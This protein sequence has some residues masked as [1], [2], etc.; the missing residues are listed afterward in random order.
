MKNLS[1]ICAI[2][3]SFLL[4]ACGGNSGSTGGNEVDFSSS[5][6]DDF[7]VDDYLD[8][9]AIGSGF[10]SGMGASTIVRGVL[11]D[12]RSG[13]DYKTIQFGPYVWMAENVND[14]IHSSYGK[15]YNNDSLLCEL[16]GKLY[17]EEDAAY[18][19]PQ[20][21]GLPSEDDYKY[22]IR[23]AG[24]LTDPEFGF[25]PQMGGSCVEEKGTVVCSNAGLSSDLV[26]GD[27]SYVRIKNKAGALF[28]KV[29]PK[30]YYSV[31]CMKFT[32]FVE[33]KKLLP[34]CDS[35]AYRF[36]DI[37]VAS[38]GSNFRCKDGKWVDAVDSYCP[39]SERGQRYYYNDVLYVCDGSWKE[40]TMN[41]LDEKCNSANEW[42]VKKLN[43]KSYICENKEW[44][45]PTEIE[46]S[47][48]LCTPERLGKIDSLVEPDTTL[49]YCGANGWR[50]AQLSDF[51]G[52]CDSTRYYKVDSYRGRHY[53]CR[54]TDKWDLLDRIEDS[55]GVCSP[56]I[57]GKMDTLKM[58][59][60]T[61][62]YYCD[63]TSW[64]EATLTDAYGECDSTKSYKVVDFMGYTYT[65][66]KNGRWESLTS[67]E[68]DIGVCTPSRL[69]KIDT[70]TSK[71]DY[72]CDST[73]WRSTVVEDYFGECDEKQK[74]TTLYFKGSDYGC[75]KGPKWTLLDFPESDLGYCIP[76]IKGTIRIDHTAK[77]YICDSVWRAA[78]KEEVLGTCSDA[79]EGERKTYGTTRY[80]CSFEAWR[81]S[82]KQDDSLG[83][84][85]KKTLKKVG[86]VGSTEYICKQ[87]GWVTYTI[88][89]AHDSCTEARA[90]TVVEFQ[91]KKYVC[92]NKAWVALTGV[93]SKYGLCTSAESGNL[94]VYG[95]KVFKCV[96]PNWTEGTVSDLLG[97]CTKAR[98]GVIDTVGTQPYFCSESEGWLPYTTLDQE[99]GF[100]E[101]SKRGTIKKRNGVEY[102][103]TYNRRKSTPRWRQVDGLDSTFGFCDGYMYEWHEAGGNDYLCGDEEDA[104]VRV[105]PGFFW[106]YY[107]YCD[108]RATW[109]YGTIVGMQGEHFYCD[110]ALEDSSRSLVGWHRITEI[111]SAAGLRKGDLIAGI[112]KKGIAGDTITVKDERYFCGLNKSSK[113][114]WIKATKV[115]DFYGKCGTS[116][117]GVRITFDGLN[118][119]CIDGVWS[120]DAADYGSFKDSRDGR[121]YKT[122]QIGDQVWMA[123]NLRYKA[124]GN[125][126][127]PDNNFSAAAC[128]T[129]GVLYD[130][131]TAL[132]L[133]SEANSIIYDLADTANH[134]GICPDGWRVPTETDWEELAEG[135]ALE[136]LRLPTNYLDTVSTN[137]YGFSAKNVG[138]VYV[139]YRNG[140]DRV[141]EFTT[142]TRYWTTSQDTYEI[143]NTGN[144]IYVIDVYNGK[145]S[146]IWKEN[147]NAL[148]CIKK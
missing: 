66:R 97:S 88:I 56:K 1:L 61:T 101:K 122:I 15:C 32:Y 130:W 48:G 74:Y 16:Y 110:G 123:E 119:Q 13:K 45:L 132:A 7:N 37:F 38:E 102:G 117:A 72:Y 41:D 50:K 71:A 62:L 55:L 139:W 75:E 83:V 144:A 63:T 142:P 104:W 64:R 22:M 85:S 49:Y 84:C 76:A 4:F 131:A 73:G 60:D 116:N 137:K 42:T 5:S 21:F 54:T 40:A 96:P 80:V 99:L 93:E 36:G 14:G 86:E 111:D 3:F 11:N 20:G 19:C 136:D 77:D 25:N 125:T 30:G 57:A 98:L 121:V 91:S 108:D 12:S 118:L 59:F 35:S 141:E 114:E 39:S 112:C 90:E 51:M 17:L 145:R 43:G 127:C 82:T 33:N 138:Y 106:G 135:R 134:Q 79:R 107:T 26:T 105:T 52:K 113:Y 81:T 28:G 53:T 103:C 23:F 94:V 58:K 6:V 146:Y 34:D 68:K 10:N 65:C 129:D 69:G 95:N 44:R 126:W 46:D 67:T 109:K 78:T 140:I 29:S 70:T 92:R 18:V 148:R 47:L 133:P 115:V 147:G 87:E 143:R 9:A 128:E 24:S 2:G 100:C 124:T 8:S 89:D 120:R 27:Y 31:R